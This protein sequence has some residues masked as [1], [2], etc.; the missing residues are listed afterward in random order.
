MVCPLWLADLRRPSM[1]PKALRVSPRTPDIQFQT[2]SFVELFSRFPVLRWSSLLFPL[3][4]STKCHSPTACRPFSIVLVNSHHFNARVGVLDR[5]YHWRFTLLLSPCS[6]RP[7]STSIAT[8]QLVLQ[9]RL[10]LTRMVFFLATIKCLL[11][12]KPLHHS[13]KE[14]LVWSLCDIFLSRL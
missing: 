10:F 2:A 14:A 12:W 6:C 8:L 11:I 4:A 5:W 9:V 3:D 7:A 13:N 1:P